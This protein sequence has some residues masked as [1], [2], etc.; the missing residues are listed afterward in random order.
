MESNAADAMEIVKQ[1][2]FEF[3]VILATGAVTEFIAQRIRITDSVLFMLTGVL[4]GP[5]VFGVIHITS[6]SV[7]NQLILIF[8]ASFI[9]FDGGASLRFNILKKVWITLAIIA[10]VGVV[11]TMVVTAVAAQYVLGISLI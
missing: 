9:I 10:T 4:L 1:L 6:T 11:I 2:L 3:G 5:E 8:G 7:L